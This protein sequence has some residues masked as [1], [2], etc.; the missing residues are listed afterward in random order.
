ML[1]IDFIVGTLLSM[2]AGLLLGVVAF[3]IVLSLQGR[4]TEGGFCSEYGI[5]RYEAKTPARMVVYMDEGWS[6]LPPSQ[7]CRVYL[8]DATGGNPSRSDEEL[9]QG[10]PPPRLLAEDTYPG[11]REYVWI[12]GAF[13]LPLGGWCLLLAVAGLARRLKVAEA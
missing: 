10:D 5:G 1:R 6:G 3:G 12:I 11:G 8:V 2:A 13:I 9:L 7:R 4:P